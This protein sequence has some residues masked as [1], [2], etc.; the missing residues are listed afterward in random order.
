[1]FDF[2]TLDSSLLLL[3]VPGAEDDDEEESLFESKAM[4]EDREVDAWAR[5]RR[6]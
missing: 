5:P 4:K 2:V 6:R 1:V 3:E